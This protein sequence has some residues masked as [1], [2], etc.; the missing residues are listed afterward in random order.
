MLDSLEQ[1]LQQMLHE[2]SSSSVQKRKRKKRR[3]RRTPRTSSRSSCGR[4]FRRQTA[5]G[6]FSGSPGDFLLRAVFPSVVVRPEMPC[7]MA[8]MDLKDRLQW[9]LQGWVLL[10][11]MLL[12]LCSFPWLAGPECSAFWA[13]MDQKDSCSGPDNAGIAGGSAPRAVSSLRQAHDA[14]HHGQHALEGQ[15]P[16]AFRKLEFLGDV[17]F[18][19]GPLY[20]EVTCSSCLPEEYMLLLF[21]EMTPGIVFVFSTP[22]CSTVDT[23]SASVYEAFWKNFTRRS[24]S[25][26]SPYSALSLVR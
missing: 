14:R 17:V 24:S 20:L 8:G 21:R 2:S 9:H 4:A 7:I 5:V 12:A 11:L 23:C 22:L 13:G 18:F 6:M 10:V 1:K 3:K 16:E 26:L 15:L 25:R 19:C